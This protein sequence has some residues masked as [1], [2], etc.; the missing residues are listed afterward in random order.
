[1]TCVRDIIAT[2]GLAVR[3]HLAYKDAPDDYRFISEDAA[4][5]QALVDKAAQHLKRTTISS[6]DRHHGQ[7]VLKGCQ[8]VLEDLLALIEK[9]KRLACINPRLVLNGVKLR[10]D[11]ITT[12]HVQLMSHTGLLNGFVRWCVF[13]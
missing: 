1:M 3:V 11:N 2:S 5:L 12:L 7:E 10:K 6:D 4:T 9:Y 8:G 13:L